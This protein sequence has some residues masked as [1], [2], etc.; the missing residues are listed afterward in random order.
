MYKFLY[1]KDTIKLTTDA[2]ASICGI[3]LYSIVPNVVDSGIT[4]SSVKDFVELVQLLA[5]IAGVIYLIVRIIDLYI[6]ICNKKISD[7]MDNMTKETEYKI[8][9]EEL[10]KLECDNFVAKW[11]NEFLKNK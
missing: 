11:N 7:K 10:K 1:Q 5:G 2:F 9:V 8:K 4:V 3:S 6:A